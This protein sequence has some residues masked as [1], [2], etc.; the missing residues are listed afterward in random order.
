MLKAAPP[1]PAGAMLL[2][3][4]DCGEAGLC[5]DDAERVWLCGTPTCLIEEFDDGGIL[6]R[7]AAAGTDHLF[8]RTL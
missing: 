6:T 1:R 7:S 8:V 4:P 5:F 2:H 3:C